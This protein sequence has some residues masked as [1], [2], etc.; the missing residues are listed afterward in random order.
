MGLS[1]CQIYL[2]LGLPPSGS[3][4]NGPPE[5]VHVL[6]LGTSECVILCGQRDFVDVIRLGILNWGENPG[7]SRW[8]SVT[9]GPYMREREVT[10]SRKGGMI[11]EPDVGVM[12]Y[13]DGGRGM[14]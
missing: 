12:H 9:Q 13:E 8:L 7:I 14:S 6:I 10:R 4:N 5:K 3:L 1:T 2:Q 11:M